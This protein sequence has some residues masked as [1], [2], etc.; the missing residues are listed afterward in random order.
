MLSKTFQ[1]VQEFIKAQVYPSKKRVV[2]NDKATKLLF[3]CTPDLYQRLIENGKNYGVVEKKGKVGKKNSKVK[4]SFTIQNL[5][6][7]TSMLPLTEFDRAVL[8]VCISEWLSGNY[9]TTPAI[10]FRALI[11]KVGD[12]NVRPRPEQRA[13]ILQS[14]DKMMFTAYDP[15]VVQ[16]FE[17]LKYANGDEIKITKSAILPCYRVEA[18][19][20][21]K[22]VEAIVMDRESPVYT[23]AALKKQ[24]LTF[25]AELLDVPNQNNTPL[26]ITLKN[27]V[28]CRIAEIKAHKMTPTLT[29]D[30][31]FT[32]C[33]I[34][35][36]SRKAKLDARNSIIKFFEHL[37]N[38]GFIKTFSLTKKKNAFY[39]IEFTY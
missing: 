32:K 31:I 17:Q 37:Q 21:G 5:D 29:F 36:K 28:I 27:Y 19:I 20:N 24:F 25:D 23:I 38:K 3:G 6:G 22:L 26:V 12:Q 7:F 15:N 18:K 2:P 30:N 39:S 1:K 33:R 8:S 9:M 13:A 14:I 16:A 11:G 10:I 34:T 35:E 4:S